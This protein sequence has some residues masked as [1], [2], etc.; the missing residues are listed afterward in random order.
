LTLHASN[1]C[2]GKK[3]FRKRKRLWNKKMKVFVHHFGFN[4]H[5]V[6]HVP[7]TTTTPCR[8]PVKFKHTMPNIIILYYYIVHRCV[9]TDRIAIRRRCYGIIIIE[10]YIILLFGIECNYY[11]S[12]I[13]FIISALKHLV[14]LNTSA[15]TPCI[16]EYIINI[17][18]IEIYACGLSLSIIIFL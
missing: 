5:A 16:S 13:L 18:Y 4:V 3:Q 8:Q 10:L 15:D 9:V 7:P 14:H 11:N 6:D 17:V 12:I 2:R 1:D